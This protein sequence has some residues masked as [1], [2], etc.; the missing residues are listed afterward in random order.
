M[1]LRADTC[2]GINLFLGETVA[3]PTAVARHAAYVA[4]LVGPEHV[5]LSLDYAPDPN[6]PEGGSENKVLAELLARNPEYWPADAGYNAPIGCLDV[7]RLPDV[8]AE[9]MAIGFDEPEI[10]GVLGANFRRI[11]EQVWK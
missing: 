8:A 1:D 7:R 4:E 10:V 3:T 6:S 2:D 11:A 9:L 5:G